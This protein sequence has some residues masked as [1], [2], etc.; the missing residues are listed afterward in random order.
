MAHTQY[1]GAFNAYNFAY[2]VNPNTPA[3][4]VISG[5]NAAGTYAVTLGLG[6]VYT[7]D[8]VAVS[9]QVGVPII[10][11]SGASTETVTP[12]A[13]VNPT[14]TLYGTCLITAVYGFGHGAG[15]LVRSGDAGIQ[16]AAQATLVYGGGLVVIDRRVYQALGLANSAALG[17]KLGTLLSLSPNIS[18]LDW[19]GTTLSKSY[20][21]A[22]G[23]AYGVT[24]VSLY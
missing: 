1:S 4:E 15:D 16:E 11:G 24:A 20:T 22:A 19:G 14:P 3:F 7:P 10:I 2:G 6:V 21:A 9:P 5:A 17:T 8:G 13:V 18:I 23:V 12:T